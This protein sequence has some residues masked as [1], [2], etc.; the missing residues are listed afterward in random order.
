MS[1]EPI[2][3]PPAQDPA[4]ADID[5]QSRKSYRRK[6][7]KMMVYFEKVMSESTGLFKEEQRMMDI[8]QRIAEQNEYVRAFSA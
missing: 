7:R 2:D 4:I 6:Y 3:V 1:A 5:R 8:A